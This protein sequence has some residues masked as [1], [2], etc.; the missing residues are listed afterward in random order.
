[1]NMYDESYIGLT[2]YNKFGYNVFGIHKS[3][4]YLYDQ[5][6]GIQISDR[7]HAEMQQLVFM[8]EL[9][10]FDS[11]KRTS[12]KLTHMIDPYGYDPTT[13]LHIV[14]YKNG[15]DIF[16]FDQKGF[17]KEGYN[18]VGYSRH[19]THKLGYDAQGF[20]INGLTKQWHTSEG[21]NFKEYAPHGYKEGY[22][23]FG[24]NQRGFDRQGF[25]LSGY[26][27]LGIDRKGRYIG[28]N[29]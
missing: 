14:G 3:W 17:N 23:I 19:G 21:I 13:G 4:Y 25:N 16:G 11:Q 9:P 6:V 18:K 20:D 27:I 2:G 29:L 7:D 26:N 8:D 1:M 12:T 15:Y 22:D 28:E 5:P 24:Y 10:P